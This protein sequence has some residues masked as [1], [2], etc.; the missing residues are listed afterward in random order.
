MVEREEGELFHFE[1][2]IRVHGCRI[3]VAYP[4][5][6][7]IYEG[8]SDYQHIVVADSP[9]GKVLILD[10]VLQ[11]SLADE[12]IYHRGLVLPALSKE[13][14]DILILGGGDG[15]AAREVRRALPNSR[16]TVVDIDPEVTRVVKHYLPEVP[17]GI[18]EDKNVKLI[19]MD[20]Y[21]Y[22]KQTSEQYDYIIGDLTDI[23]EE[24]EIGSEVNRLYREE[25][26]RELNRILKP[27]GTIV[28]HVTGIV[29]GAKYLGEFWDTCRK[30]F[31]YTVGY[32]IHIPTFI[33]IWGYLAMSNSPINLD[34]SK[35]KLVV[36]KKCRKRHIHNPLCFI[37]S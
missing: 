24:A 28:Y 17:R 23:R 15:G 34:K 10:G 22:V 1:Y 32:A 29:F 20:A 21:D 30:V 7:V 25:F 16:I 11:L 26:L 8:S 3:F 12:E 2:A 5:K 6:E 35:V 36:L 33:D 37:K 14:R 4:I 31:K 19:N 27:G 9:L 13:Y 18:F